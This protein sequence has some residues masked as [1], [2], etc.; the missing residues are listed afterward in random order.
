MPDPPGDD[1]GVVEHKYDRFSNFIRVA[2]ER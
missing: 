2:E 1:L